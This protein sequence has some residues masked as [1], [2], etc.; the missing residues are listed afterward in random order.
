MTHYHR[1]NILLALLLIPF[2]LKVLGCATYRP[3]QSYSI[4]KERVYQ[5]P[6]DDVWQKTVEWFATQGTPVKNMDK[7]SGFIATEYN[8]SAERAKY[9]M[10]CGKEG[11]AQNI[12]N[13]VGN[14]NVVI[15]KVDDTE[16]KVVVTTFF[17]AQ[18]IDHKINVLTGEAVNEVTTID[19]NSTGVL[20]KELL[21]YIG[22]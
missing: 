3:P 20:E 4:D 9:V 14:F 19:C 7:S 5:K 1:L 16:T 6:F 12:E 21:E 10:D 2:A 11:S 8:L 13:H 15:K 17:K 22:R 18:R